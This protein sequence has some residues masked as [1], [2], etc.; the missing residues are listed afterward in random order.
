M[1]IESSDIQLLKYLQENHDVPL[2]GAAA[3]F[4]RNPSSLRRQI[5]SINLEL[6]SLCQISIC[7]GRICS[8]L[9]YQ[10]YLD[11]IQSLSMETYVP[12]CKERMQLIIVEAFFKDTVNLSRLYETLDFSVTTKKSDTARLRPLLFAYGQTIQVVKK[13]GI[14]IT[15]D[16]LRLR[17]LLIEILLP[18]IEWEPAAGMTKR[19]ANTP[20]QSVMA[21][22][23]IHSSLSPAQ[24]EARFPSLFL[25][26]RDYHLSYQSRKLLSLYLCLSASRQ[27]AHPVTATGQVLLE[28]PHWDM[29]D[30]SLENRAL[31][32]MISMMDFDPGPRLPVNAALFGHAIRLSDAAQRLSGI[33]F[34]EKERVH[35]ELYR[36]LY[37][38]YFQDFYGIQIKDKMVRNTER[39]FPVLYQAIC[40]ELIPASQ[41]FGIRF[42]AE[43][44]TTLTLILQKWI[45]YCQL[46]GQNRKAIVLVTNT[47]SERSG[48]FISAL[49]DLVEFRLS[50]IISIHEL[51]LLQKLS[52]D[53]IITLSDRTADMLAGQGY[54]SL[55]LEFFL[56][57]EDLGKLL[58]A[59]FDTARKRLPAKT[60]A[61]SLDGLP[62]GEIAK[63][64]KR[65]YPEHFI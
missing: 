21:D 38:I 54:P 41:E 15:G 14:R 56:G 39:Q 55:R 4:Y 44:Y 43:H 28:P 6:G 36:Y 10:D 51:E 18:L 64:L 58:A 37:K 22:A 45:H 59:G 11:I 47:S 60:I 16:E 52:Y 25:K 48:F 24:L 17:M 32:H 26:I 9:T 35:E 13:K 1:P 27:A 33:C 57:T 46:A 30:D 50:A 34:T 3:D 23:C 49:E 19:H 5:A 62:S 40:N 61:D 42:Q 2:T 20:I 53:Y 29:L 8:R 7:N 63:Q 12:S 31:L 65:D